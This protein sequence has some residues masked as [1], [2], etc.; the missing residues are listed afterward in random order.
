M[1]VELEAGKE[2]VGEVS[3]DGLVNVYV[4]TEENLT[5]IDA[6]E[7]FW[8]ETCEEGVE[9]AA[10]HFTASE[11]GTWFLVV[12]NADVKDVTATVKVRVNRAAKN[13]GPDRLVPSFESLKIDTTK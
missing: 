11:N 9:E 10:V 2:L 13:T 4:L 6:G 1:D 7:E 8:S 12:E 5:S 3:A